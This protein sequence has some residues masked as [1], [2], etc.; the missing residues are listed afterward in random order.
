MINAQS[1][2]NVIA[3]AALFCSKW[4]SKDRPSVV[5]G[6]K[7]SIQRGVTRSV[8]VSQMKN[9]TTDRC[10]WREKWVIGITMGEG[11]IFF[12]ILCVVKFK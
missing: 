12:A 9:T 4:G 3:A 1:G 8:V 10:N 7:N 6:E 11:L 5:K 2:A